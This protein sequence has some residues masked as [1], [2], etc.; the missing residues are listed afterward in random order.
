MVS[1]DTG[2][3]LLPFGARLRLKEEFDI[4]GYSETNQIIL[5][6]LKKYGL[7]LADVGSSMFLSGAPHEGW[8]NDELRELKNVQV[9]DFEVVEM[10]KITSSF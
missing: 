1:G 7:I 4:T 5:R 10:G 9:K 3:E 6:A 8:D 2:D